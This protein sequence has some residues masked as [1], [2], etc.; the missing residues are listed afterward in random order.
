MN[1]YIINYQ[2]N[3]RQFFWNGVLDVN[4]AEVYPSEKVAQLKLDKLIDEHKK[5]IKFYQDKLDTSDKST[6]SLYNDFIAQ[7]QEF[8]DTAKI[9]PV[10]VSVS[11]MVTEGPKDSLELDEAYEAMGS[12]VLDNFRTAL[13]S[14][15]SDE[16]S[17]S[18]IT[19]LLDFNDLNADFNGELYFIKNAVDLTNTT[20]VV[21]LIL[22]SAETLL[23]DY[24]IQSLMEF[25]SSVEDEGDI[26]EYREPEDW[27]MVDQPYETDSTDVEPEPE[28]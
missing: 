2:S 22:N 10:K 19:K 26:G 18:T 5:S 27:L 20:E 7:Y 25:L 11:M 14:S 23:S 24:E 3:G 8:I 21:N 17:I 1:K 16:G 6:P 15:I 12:Q 9:Q 28:E 13:S 4:E